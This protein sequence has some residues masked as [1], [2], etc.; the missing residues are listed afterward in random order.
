MKTGVFRQANI[1]EGRPVLEQAYLDAVAAWKNVRGSIAQRDP[2]SEEVDDYYKR[3][4][5]EL[6][7]EQK[8][9]YIKMERLAAELI[10]GPGGP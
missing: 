5:A 7:P 8:Q 10:S 4:I 2:Q 9:A 3:V 6:N 1:L